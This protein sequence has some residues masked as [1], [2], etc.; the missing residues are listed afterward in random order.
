MLALSHLS[1]ATNRLS[2]AC[3]LGVVLAVRCPWGRAAVP[4]ADK[5][6][7]AQG[8]AGH[9]AGEGRLHSSPPVQGP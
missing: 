2:G 4:D 3:N 5:E 1:P 8:P 7:E 6:T 9:T